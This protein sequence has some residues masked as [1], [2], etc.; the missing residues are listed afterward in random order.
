MNCSTAGRKEVRPCLHT[1]L[2]SQHSLNDRLGPL[3][4]AHTYFTG[5]KELYFHLVLNSRLFM[6][7]IFMKLVF[8]S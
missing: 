3:V 4:T 2:N 6:N 1:R 8:T 5:I 7:N